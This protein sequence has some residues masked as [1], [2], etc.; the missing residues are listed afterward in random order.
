VIVAIVILYLPGPLGLAS[1][2]TLTTYLALGL[3]G[4][5]IV[6]PVAGAAVFSRVLR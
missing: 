4:L 2:S 5:V 3:V 6:A 1:L